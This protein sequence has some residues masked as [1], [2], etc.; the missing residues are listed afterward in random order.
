MAVESTV[1]LVRWRRPLPFWRP[2]HSMRAQAWFGK[3]AAAEVAAPEGG[4][5]EAEGGT[6]TSSLRPYALGRRG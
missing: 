2:N 1:Y 4:A 3:A 6:T 5:D